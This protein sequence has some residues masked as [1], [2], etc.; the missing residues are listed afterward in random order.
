M[1]KVENPLSAA[2][3]LGQSARF[4]PFLMKIA[5]IHAGFR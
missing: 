3:I 4:R 1:E 2:E 5:E